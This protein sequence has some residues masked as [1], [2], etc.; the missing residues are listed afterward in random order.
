VVAGKWDEI[1]N[2]LFG[3]NYDV[4]YAALG[5]SDAK[6]GCGCHCQPAGCAAVADA[7]GFTELSLLFIQ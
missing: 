7:A 3:A 1:F 2:P 6:G 4:H 5:N